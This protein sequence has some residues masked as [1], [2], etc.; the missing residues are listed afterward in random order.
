MTL[1]DFLTEKYALCFDLR[2]STDSTLHGNGARFENTSEG[3]T[4][5]I[6]RVAGTGNGKAELTHFCVSGRAV[7]YFGRPVPFNRSLIFSRWFLDVF[8]RHLRNDQLCQRSAHCNFHRSYELWQDTE[9]SRSQRKF[10]ALRFMSAV[11]TSGFFNARRAS[12]VQLFSPL[13]EPE[14][15]ER[16]K[17]R[18]STEH[19]FR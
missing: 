19:F 16:N 12:F 10:F 7:K 13:V 17:F 8:F 15:V 6:H 9:G 4:L 2:P 5:E 11:L 3:I 18:A 1:I 14:V